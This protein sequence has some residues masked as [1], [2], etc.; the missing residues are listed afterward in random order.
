VGGKKILK[1]S[2]VGV[3]SALNALVAIKVMPMTTTQKKRNSFFV[4]DVSSLLA[5]YG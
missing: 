3:D 2:L 1:V 4:I 5:R